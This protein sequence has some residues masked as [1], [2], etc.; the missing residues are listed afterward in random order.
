KSSLA[1]LR[2]QYA[3]FAL[4]QRRELQGERLE[5]EL[6]YWKK[7]LRGAA[8]LLNFPT[9]KPRPAMQSSKGAR[10]SWSA[11]PVSMAE[12]KAFSRLRGLTPFMFLLAAFKT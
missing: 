3:D 10:L 8:A 1:P 5:Q 4:S 2:I 9:D 7:R 12:I 6:G 11:S